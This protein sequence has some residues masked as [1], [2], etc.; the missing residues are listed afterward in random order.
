MKW[1]NNLEKVEIEGKGFLLLPGRARRLVVREKTE[2]TTHFREVCPDD[3]GY[4]NA[5]FEYFVVADDKFENIYRLLCK[6]EE[7]K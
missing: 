4:D 7:I 2:D 1:L 3:D 5:P 6:R